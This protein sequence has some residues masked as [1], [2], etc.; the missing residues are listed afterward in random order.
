MVKETLSLSRFILRSQVM[1]LYRD[2][3]RTINPINDI[4]SKNELKQWIRQDF[5]LNKSVKDEEVIRMHL[6]RGRLALRELQVSI[7]M[8]ASSGFKKFQIN[9]KDMKS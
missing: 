5:Q 9:N 1:D 8:P 7:S 4:K 3:L 2:F 6:S